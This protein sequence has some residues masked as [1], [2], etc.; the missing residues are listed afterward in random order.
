MINENNEPK[1]MK[2]V[3]IEHG[4]WRNGLNADCQLCKNKIEDMNWTNCCAQRIISLQPDFLSQKSM[5]EEVIL[6]A[7]HRCIFYLK[8][9][10]K[11][12]YIERYWGQRKDMPMKIVTILGR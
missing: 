2:Q 5:L 3:L 12:N 10:C 8:F 11:L 7:G 6:E 9:H 4:L 1:G